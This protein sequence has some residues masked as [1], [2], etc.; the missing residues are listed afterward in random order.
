M[1][2]RVLANDRP[3]VA[4]RRQS[5]VHFLSKNKNSDQENPP[6]VFFCW[7][8]PQVGLKKTDCK[9]SMSYT[10]IH[11]YIYVYIYMICFNRQIY[12]YI[13]IYIYIYIL[14]WDLKCTVPLSK[15]YWKKKRRKVYNLFQLQEM[16]QYWSVTN[17]S[18]GIVSSWSKV[19]VSRRCFL[20][21]TRSLG[22]CSK[23][24]GSTIT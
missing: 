15:S 14:Y 18:W 1:D 8:L 22:R 17:S 6:W 7:R 13:S 2:Q 12:I 23:W 10:Y 24:G 16:V 21:P 3:Q 19:V 9:V 4:W 11:T 20:F 5:T